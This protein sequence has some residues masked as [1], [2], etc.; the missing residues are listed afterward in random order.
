MGRFKGV[1]GGLGS[2][3]AMVG[4]RAHP[5]Q[6]AAGDGRRR[7]APRDHSPPTPLASERHARRQREAETC[8]GIITRNVLPLPTSLTTSIRPWWASTMSR[9]M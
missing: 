6:S 4:R 8:E 5:V 2:E 1:G 3:R 7:A 9:V